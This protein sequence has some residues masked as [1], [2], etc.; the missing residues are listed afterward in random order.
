MVFCQLSPTSNVFVGDKPRKSSSQMVLET[1]LSILRYWHRG[2]RNCKAISKATGIP[3]RTV[4]Y[5]VRLLRNKR[6]IPV[7]TKAGRPPKLNAHWSR[8]LAR[9]LQHHWKERKPLRWYIAELERRGGP[10]I[11]A[12]TLR[13]YLA[14]FGYRYV[15]WSP[16]RPLTEPQRKARLKWCIDHLHDWEIGHFLTFFLSN[17]ML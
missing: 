8:S 12:S 16:R 1:Q 14:K 10:K 9:L 15:K 3:L 13:T 4:Q 17:I 2:E 7:S 6:K 5:N 11:S